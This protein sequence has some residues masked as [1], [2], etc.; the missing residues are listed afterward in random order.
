MRLLNSAN[1][2]YLLIG[3]YAVGCHGYVRYTD[4][5]DFWVAVTAGNLQSVRDVLV[6]FGFPAAAVPDPLFT[7]SIQILRIGRP[8]NK[9]ELF[10]MIPGVDFDSCYQRRDIVTLEDGLVVNVLSYSDLIASKLAGARPK[11]LA[12]VDELEKIHR[13]KTKPR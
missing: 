3:G 9:L 13:R 12:D 8:P 2:E 5:I 11:D 6:K 4:D 7:Q 1:V 10:S